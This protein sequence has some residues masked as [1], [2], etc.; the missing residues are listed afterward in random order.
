MPE[1]I[2]NIID[3]FQVSFFAP[4]QYILEV[5]FREILWIDEYKRH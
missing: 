1:G 2:T 3:L 4:F 5:M